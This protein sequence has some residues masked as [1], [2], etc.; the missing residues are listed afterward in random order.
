MCSCASAS[1]S[2]PKRRDDSSAATSGCAGSAFAAGAASESGASPPGAMLSTRRASQLTKYRSPSRS[3]LEM[4]S[5]SAWRPSFEK[6]TSPNARSLSAAHA[7]ADMPPGRAVTTGT[8]RPSVGSTHGERVT[9]T[10]GPTPRTSGTRDASRP[11]IATWPAGRPSSGLATPTSHASARKAGWET[12]STSPV[13]AAARDGQGDGGAS[14]PPPSSSSSPASS[15]PA[16]APW[17]PRG[18]RLLPPA[19]ASMTRGGTPRASS[20]RAIIGEKRRCRKEAHGGT[21]RASLP[22]C[23]LV[24]DG[25]TRVTRS[26][27]RPSAALAADGGSFRIEGGSWM[28]EMPR[29]A[30]RMPLKTPSAGAKRRTCTAVAR[31]AALPPPSSSASKPS[32]TK[33]QPPDSLE[34][35]G[36]SMSSKWSLVSRRNACSSRAGDWK[37]SRREAALRADGSVRQSA[38]RSS[39]ACRSS[40]GSPSDGSPKQGPEAA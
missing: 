29:L 31:C 6:T 27:A 23:R 32:G 4:A 14:S 24:R 2:S 8:T 26:S 18:P 35:C 9:K 7:S 38:H 16:C 3:P 17:G 15:P 13:A 37:S 25:C 11:G 20:S 34:G 39:S 40:G 5:G 19:Y 21:P 36:S 33:P 1:Q 28:R 10:Q 22:I 30:A 12:C